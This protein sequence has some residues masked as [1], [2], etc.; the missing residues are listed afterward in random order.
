MGLFSKKDKDDFREQD[1]TDSTDERTIELR[2]EELRLAWYE[3]HLHLSDL[4]G[5][6]CEEHKEKAA[7]LLGGLG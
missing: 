3:H 7:R 5:R 2:E 1:L 6:L 4:H